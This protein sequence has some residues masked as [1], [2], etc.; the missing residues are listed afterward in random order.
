MADYA[1]QTVWTEGKEEN[2]E[3]DRINAIF[4]KW[5]SLRNDVGVLSAAGTVA[6]HTHVAAV[7]C[8]FKWLNSVGVYFWEPPTTHLLLLH[9]QYVKPTADCIYHKLSVFVSSVC[10]TFYLSLLFVSSYSLTFLGAVATGAAL[11]PSQQTASPL[12]WFSSAIFQAILIW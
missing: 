8:H 7:Y 2:S 9:V 3:Y 10:S 4:P 12:K 1:E 6:S 5:N 11:L